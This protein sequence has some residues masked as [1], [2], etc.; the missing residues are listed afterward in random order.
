MHASK[1]SSEARQQQETGYVYDTFAPE[2]RRRGLRRLVVRLVG[3]VFE[4]VGGH[5]HRADRHAVQHPQV[6]EGLGTIPPTARR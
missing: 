1:K 5:E 6:V 3:R 4:H 2:H